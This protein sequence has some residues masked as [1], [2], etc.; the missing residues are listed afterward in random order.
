MKS[1]TALSES[2]L[3]IT[4]SFHDASNIEETMHA[5]NA[6]LCHAFEAE[7]ITLYLVGDDG[8]HLYSGDAT[9]I[10]KRRRI[11]LSLNLTSV[12]GYVALVRK[13]VNIR[14]AY[15]EKEL[16]ALQP[17]MTFLGGADAKTGFHTREMLVAPVLDA[18]SGRLLGVLQILNRLDCQPFPKVCEDAIVE[19]C[20]ALAPPLARLAKQREE[21]R[22]ANKMRALEALRIEK[23]R[24]EAADG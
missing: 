5:A 24:E 19:L 8:S 6:D 10:E 3:A 13:V 9:G 23:E 20:K 2:L 7:R 14:N 22:R 21:E 12:A 15:D 17:P 4:S 18:S 1:D 11:K 16:S